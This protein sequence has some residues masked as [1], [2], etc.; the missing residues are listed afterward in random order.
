MAMVEAY[1]APQIHRCL[2]RRLTSVV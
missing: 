2:Y 1:I